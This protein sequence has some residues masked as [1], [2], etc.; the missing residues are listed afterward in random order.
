MTLFGTKQRR[1]EPLE[2]SKDWK[3][4]ATASEDRMVEREANFDGG[5]IKIGEREVE[6]ERRMQNE[7]GVVCRSTEETMKDMAI[8]LLQVEN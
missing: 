6:C 8:A 3:K 7:L 1:L 2:G 5:A 4:T